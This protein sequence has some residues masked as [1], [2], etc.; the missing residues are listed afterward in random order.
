MRLLLLLLAVSL[1]VEAIWTNQFGWLWNFSRRHEIHNNNEKN[2]TE[3][4]YELLWSD[5]DCWYANESYDNEAASRILVPLEQEDFPKVYNLLAISDMDEDSK[6]VTSWTWRAVIRRG[7]LTIDHD[8]TNVTVT[9]I[10]DSDKNLTT[11]F[12]YKGRAMELSDLSK[13]NGRLLSPDDKTGLLYEIKNNKAIP[14]LFLNSGPG[15]STK[16]MKAEW[17]TLYGGHLIV[18]GHGTEYRNKNGAVVSEDSMW[19]K[20][21]SG[22]GEVKSCNWKYIY[23]RLLK[24]VNLTGCGAY[25]THEAAQWSSIHQKWFFL[26]RKESNETY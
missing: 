24:A 20:V 21:I 3:P 22:S 17:T 15:N 12:N 11:P 7:N 10:N 13:F 2:D 1:S 14:W 9:W 19:I 26:P 18:G 23:K 4:G 5:D 6:S 25:L 8:Q 16:G